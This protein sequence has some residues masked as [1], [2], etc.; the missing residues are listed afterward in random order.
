MFRFEIEGHGNVRKGKKKSPSLSSSKNNLN[1][2]YPSTG[3]LVGAG[4]RD[5]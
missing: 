5:P 4:S 3:A 2:L 1:G